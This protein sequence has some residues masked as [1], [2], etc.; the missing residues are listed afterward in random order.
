MTHRRGRTATTSR[1]T[2]STSTASTA[3]ASTAG[4]L[5]GALVGGLVMATALGAGTVLGPAA[6]AGLGLSGLPARLL[7]AALVSALAVPLLVVARRGRAGR[8]LGFGGPRASLRAFLTGTGV[9]AAAAALV[10][11][12]ATAAGLLRWSRPDPGALAGFLASNA[13]VALL[14]EALPE[15]TALRGHAWTALRGRFGGTVAALGTTAVF[16]LVPGASTVV[17]AGTAWLIGA[18]RQP[19]GFAP[20]GQPAADYLVLLAVFGLTLVAAR[21]AVDRAPLWAAIGAHLTFLTVNRIV[22]EGA[23]RG[24]GWSARLLTPDA[25]L[26]VPAYLLVAA[27]GFLVCRRI[28]RTRAAERTLRAVR[29]RP[30]PDDGSRA[31]RRRAVGR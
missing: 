1:T 2:P 15:E 16:L 4:A 21:T 8:P 9:T 19:V 28:T 10:L 11:G 18:E 24:A 27:A 6:A 30:G 3:T 25:V 5:R 13:V 20:G 22:L 7:P 14:L 12:A 29:E 26:L 31:S 17:G 23:E